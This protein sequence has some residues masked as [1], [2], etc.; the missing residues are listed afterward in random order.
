MVAKRSES[1]NE[2]RDLQEAQVDVPHTCV[3]SHS[4]AV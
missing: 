1:S 4:W 3:R 2:I